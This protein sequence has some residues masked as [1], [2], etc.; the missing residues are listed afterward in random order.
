ML[1]PCSHF[2]EATV[3]MNVPLQQDPDQLL[4]V[5]PRLVLPELPQHK[6][7][8]QQTKSPVKLPSVAMGLQRRRHITTW[9]NPETNLRIPVPNVE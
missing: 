2:L 4:A 3:D 9:N 5:N 6:H 8:E 1:H 7:P